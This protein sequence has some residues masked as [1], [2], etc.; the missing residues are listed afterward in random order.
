VFRYDFIPAGTDKVER[1]RKALLE[2]DKYPE[3]ET[4]KDLE[5]HVA[6]AMRGHWRN[7]LEARQRRG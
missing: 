6:S 5:R 4:E 2:Y 1:S 3:D 7:Y